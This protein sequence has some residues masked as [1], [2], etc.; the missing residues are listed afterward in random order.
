MQVRGNNELTC[1]ISCKEGSWSLGCC[2]LHSYAVIRHANVGVLFYS[3]HEC[4]RMRVLC[5]C[6][7]YVYLF[8]DAFRAG[9]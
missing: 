4:A 3:T 8:H 7:M 1:C 9:D 5:G 6:L 2:V